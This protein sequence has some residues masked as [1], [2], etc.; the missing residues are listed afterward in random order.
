V[1]QLHLQFSHHLGGDC[2]SVLPCAPPAGHG[3]ERGGATDEE[4][5]RGKE[6]GIAAQGST[7]SSS[8]QQIGTAPEA[9]SD[10]TEEIDLSLKL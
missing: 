1:K 4:A 8:T 3:G 10:L 9:R 7:A 5:R 6:L 2:S